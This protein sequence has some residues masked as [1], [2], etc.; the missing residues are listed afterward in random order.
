MASDNTNTLHIYGAGLLCVLHIVHCSVPSCS[1]V[2]LMCYHHHITLAHTHENTHTRQQTNVSAR[3]K[4]IKCTDVRAARDQTVPSFVLV[5]ES[6][7]SAFVKCNRK[8]LYM[9]LLYGMVI[10]SERFIANTE[11]SLAGS[12]RA[13]R[14]EQPSPTSIVVVQSFW[15]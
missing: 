7:F 2:C 1:S 5:L 3:T 11:S 14:A 6:C 9:L 4:K 13:N 12:T 8:Y 10:Q 15:N